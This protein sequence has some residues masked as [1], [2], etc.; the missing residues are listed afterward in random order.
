M[1]TDAPDEDTG[2]GLSKAR[3]TSLSEAPRLV[4]GAAPAPLRVVVD[5]T[6]A[7]SASRELRVHPLPLFPGPLAFHRNAEFMGSDTSNACTKGSAGLP[8]ARS[9]EPLTV[10]VVSCVIKL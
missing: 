4:F 6:T 3:M 8:A 1:E 9:V 2:G 10:S 7:G 5:S